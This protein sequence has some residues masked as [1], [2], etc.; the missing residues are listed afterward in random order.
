VGK[1]KELI[2]RRNVLMIKLIWVFLL[3]DIGIN[4]LVRNYPSLFVDFL[5]V[6]NRSQM[7][8]LNKM[9]CN[10]IQRYLVS[11]PLPGDQFESA[12]LKNT[13]Q[14]TGV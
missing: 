12:I 13:N 8:T 14:L 4:L 11:R 9:G 1:S 10:E 6:E 7:D 2:H 5:G 3:L